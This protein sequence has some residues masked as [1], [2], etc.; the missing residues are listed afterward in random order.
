MASVYISLAM[1]DFRYLSESPQ[2][3]KWSA[4][5]IFP[6]KARLGD[7][8]PE[9]VAEVDNQS[10]ALPIFHPT[11]FLRN[12]QAQILPDM[13]VHYCFYRHE[14]LPLMILRI[15]V[16]ESPYNTRL[17]F[18]G[19]DGKS[20]NFDS[21]R[22]MYIG[23]PDSSPYVYISKAQ[24]N[25]SFQAGEAKTLFN[26]VIEGIP[27]ALSKP[28]ERFTIRYTD[29]S[30]KNLAELIERRGPDRTPT[31]SSFWPRSTTSSPTGTPSWR[32]APTSRRLVEDGRLE[33]MG[34]TY[35]EPNTNL[36]GAETTIR[37]AVYG[38]GSQ[39]H[40]LGGEPSTAWQLD[41]FGH[42]PQFP[43]G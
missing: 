38:V 37:N 12:L 27:K 33:I 31:T 34:G 10:A 16:L 43:A 18:Q 30:T 26:A 28:R 40:V 14:T 24:T 25:V 22:S 35:N 1:A 4:Y 7:D 29:L 32:T 6:V 19:E 42:D 9:D 21:S 41:A 2:F 23:F 17:A 39:R 8:G 13:K 5:R 3:L 36:T 11:A 15:L 20:T